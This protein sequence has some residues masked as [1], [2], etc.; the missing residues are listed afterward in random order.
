MGTHVGSLEGISIIRAKREIDFGTFDFYTDLNKPEARW[1]GCEICFE[2][3]LDEA[4]GV[5]NNKQ[6]VELRSLKRDEYENDEVKPMWLQL[7]PVV[8]KTIGEMMKINS[9]I[10]RESR[11]PGAY[12]NP[13]AT[14]II[15]IVEGKNPTEGKTDIVKGEVLLEELEECIEDVLEEITGTN[16]TSEDVQKYLGN[17]VNFLYKDRGSARIFDHT[18]NLGTTI[19]Y[20]NTSHIFYKNFLT[21]FIDDGDAKTSFELFIGALI[22][23]VE[24]RSIDESEQDYIETLFDVWNVKLRKYISEQTGH[25]K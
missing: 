13:P 5:A 24:E 22:K 23:V 12:V 15:N 10:R 3:E 2:P 25:K 19:I 20:I 16:P 18:F 1:W 4:F 17:K 8:N 9:E 6:H 11:K 7:H 14:D 21:K